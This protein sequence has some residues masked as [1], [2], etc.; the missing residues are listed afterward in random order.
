MISHDEEEAF[1]TSAIFLEWKTTYAKI[2]HSRWTNTLEFNFTG[3]Y[4]VEIPTHQ[5]KKN[6]W[7]G[8]MDIKVKNRS[9]IVLIGE[10]W[11]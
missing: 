6:T 9:R 7:L 4:H 3:T 10:I 5:E 11:S 2:R 8:N 1:C